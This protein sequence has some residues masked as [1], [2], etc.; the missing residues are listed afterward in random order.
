M[1]GSKKSTFADDTAD[2]AADVQEFVEYVAEELEGLREKHADLAAEAKP[3]ADEGDVWSQLSRTTGTFPDVDRALAMLTSTVRDLAD[4]AAAAVA[5]RKA[6][7]GD[8]S[9]DKKA[10]EPAV[11]KSTDKSGD[12]KK[13]S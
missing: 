7:D 12:S 4:A 13:S 8:D 9:G 3:E 5:A 10:E 6:D 11:K 1:T 2:F